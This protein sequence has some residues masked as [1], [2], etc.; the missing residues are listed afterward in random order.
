MLQEV[1]HG[2]RAQEGTPEESLMEENRGGENKQLNLE[3]QARVSSLLPSS[4][5]WQYF[6][7]WSEET[8]AKV[9]KF[10]L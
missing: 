5:T 7:L 9:S 1:T 4:Y 3:Q 10:R 2:S 8:V 6:M